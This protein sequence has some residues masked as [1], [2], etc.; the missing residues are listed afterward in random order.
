M[1]MLYTSYKEND[2]LICGAAA[3]AWH[4]GAS[5]HNCRPLHKPWTSKHSNCL[6]HFPFIWL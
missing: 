1:L 6:Q 4:P 3:V 5:K 2:I